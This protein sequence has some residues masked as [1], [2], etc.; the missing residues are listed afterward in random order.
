[1]PSDDA[2]PTDDGFL[3]R[4][5]LLAE[6]GQYDEAVAELGQAIT[7]DRENAA[8][9]SLLA[10]VQLAANRPAEALDAV[11]RAL[12]VE[13][14]SL[15]LLVRRALALIDLRRFGEAARLADAMLS[16]AP[17]SAY[18]QRSGAAI[19]GEARNGQAALNAAWRAVALAPQEPEGHLV[20]GVVAARLQQYD[21]A[22]RAYR[23]ALR[24]D[25]DIA[26][27]GQT[28]GIATL[29]R[30][31]YAGTLEQLAEVATFMAAPRSAPDPDRRV[32]SDAVRQ[33]IIY[34]GAYTIVAAVIVACLGASNGLAGRA[35]GAIVAVVGGLLIWSYARRLPAGR[36]RALMAT[37]RP[38]G[39]AV[40]ATIAGPALILIYALVGT[41][42][43]LALAVIAGATAEF[44]AFTRAR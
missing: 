18:A 31:R 14:G 26:D 34:G 39:L 15:A 20:L 29:E 22:E 10:S 25:E 1:V 23:E 7:L 37:D 9:L 11:D 5:E 21:L 36:L 19:L 44:A 17:D 3:R 33:L 30:R 40:Y 24:L 28:V 27:A 41:P 2:V 35:L 8:A 43:P 6:L 42:W 38:L 16:A 12:A 4:A 13:P 32:A